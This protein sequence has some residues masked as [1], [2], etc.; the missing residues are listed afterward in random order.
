MGKLDIQAKSFSELS[1]SELYALL[2]L[3]AEVFVLE[4]ECAYQDLDNYDQKAI[5]ICAYQGE[6]LVAYTRLLAPGVK[7]SGAS[8]GR[9]V[10]AATVRKN[11][12]GKEILVFSINHSKQH[13]PST[14]ITISAQEYLENF[15]KELGFKTMSEPYM[16]DGIP[17]VEMTLGG[18]Q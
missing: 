12:Y 6:D 7:Y 4:Q 17:H 2:R 16:E 11:G 9:V 18:S 5:H 3:R 8:I 14:A 1:N 13:W 10:T 15:Y